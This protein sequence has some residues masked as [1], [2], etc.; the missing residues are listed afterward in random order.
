MLE[1]YEKKYSLISSFYLLTK[2]I[3][4]LLDQAQ[5]LTQEKTMDAIVALLEKRS[6][7]VTQVDALDQEIRAKKRDKSEAEKIASV[8][9]SIQ[10]V[11]GKAIA[12][13]GENQKI[14]ETC[15][16][17]LSGSMKEINNA[18]KEIKAYIPAE[19]VSMHI[20]VSQ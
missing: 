6:Q 9:H 5:E 18:Q 7:V 2:D 16:K 20:D 12:L 4:Q 15:M 1:L 11:L 13:D 17:E 3:Q 10:I 14:I 8:Q 19:D